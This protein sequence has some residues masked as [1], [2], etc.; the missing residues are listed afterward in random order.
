MKVNNK[1]LEGI[2]VWVFNLK[3]CK[4]RINKNWGV[5]IKE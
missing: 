2:L 3:K 4:L 5:K 1:K